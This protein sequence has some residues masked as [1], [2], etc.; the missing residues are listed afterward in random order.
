MSTLVDVALGGREDGGHAGFGRRSRRCQA[1]R[2]VLFSSFPSSWKSRADVILNNADNDWINSTKLLNVRLLLYPSLSFFHFVFLSVF[3]SFFIPFTSPTAHFRRWPVLLVVSAICTS[4]TKPRGAFSAEELFI[5]RA[6]GQFLFPFLFPV[7][8]LL[9]LSIGSLSK[10][11]PNSLVPTISTTAS[12][13]FSTP[14]SAN[15][16]SAPSTAS[17][18]TS[19]SVPLVSVSSFRGRKS[20]NSTP[21]SSR[22]R[23]TALSHS[24]RC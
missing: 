11:P 12:T 10:P 14:T 23:R 20:R 18:P 9:S 3:F 5:S 16:S 8:D 19:S 13:L 21:I 22:I 24:K 17:E 2:C 4:R 15:S 1:G 7:V 6:S